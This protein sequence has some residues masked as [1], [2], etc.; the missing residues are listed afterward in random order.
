MSNQNFTNEVWKGLSG[1]DRRS[2]AGRAPKAPGAPHD[3]DRPDGG[4]GKWSVLL[5]R[6]F[7][8]RSD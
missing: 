4:R 8:R 6:W 1:G 3:P 2:S 5:S 7:G